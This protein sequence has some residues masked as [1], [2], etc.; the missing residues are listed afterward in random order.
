MGRMRGWSRC[1]RLIWDAVRTA[2]ITLALRFELAKSEV[3]RT[4]IYLLWV[5]VFR[6]GVKVYLYG[7]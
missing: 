3:D 4:P 2:T 6:R 7:I 1:F 5:N